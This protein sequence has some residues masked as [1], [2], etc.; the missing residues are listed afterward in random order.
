MLTI[1]Y[2][3]RQL[4]EFLVIAIAVSLV[5]CIPFKVAIGKLFKCNLRIIYVIFVILYLV[6]L[7][8]VVFS[9][10][11]SYGNIRIFNG[12]LFAVYEQA[13]IHFSA[14]AIINI[15]FNILLFVPW[16]IL[17]Y[18]PLKDSR[19]RILIIPAGIIVSILIEFSQYIFSC[20]IADVADIFNNSLGVV[21]GYAIIS[22]YFCLKE[23][24]IKAALI[25]LLVIFIVMA[26]PGS[27]Y[28]ISAK[29]AYGISEY[30]EVCGLSFDPEDVF[31]CE[32]LDHA[33]FGKPI[34]IYSAKFGSQEDALKT[35][36]YIYG[37]LGT[38][39]GDTI[40][41][42][43][44]CFIFDQNREF[45]IRYFYAGPG[46][47]LRRL[48][49]VE[50]EQETQVDEITLRTL[51]ENCGIIVPASS[52]FIC[53]RDNY[54]TFLLAPPSVDGEAGRITVKYSNGEI[55]ELT[56]SLYK[57][58]IIDEVLIPDVDTIKQKITSGSFYIENKDALETQTDLRIISAEI[59]YD[60]DSKAI[61]RP[62][63]K[64]SIG[65]DP[66]IE[67]IYIPL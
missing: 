18:I 3:L 57:V 37:H 35:A 14:S 11:D 9:N 5:L 30:D 59:M 51:I 16:G 20:G 28:I 58:T 33:L 64:L 45:C 42:D 55:L 54:Y 43:E 46:F 22:A 56:Y 4:M 10:R 41:Y 25:S 44:E 2:Y 21:M 66:Y 60:I 12:S 65:A 1:S 36:E 38:C 24:H 61:Y 26:F 34:P 48:M 27:V 6:L 32:D 23:R 8:Q 47:Y 40:Q 53:E 17:F 67:N 50:H 7:F 52:S 49:G 15:V 63:L 13:A 31:I 29:R 39:I 62:F 19:K